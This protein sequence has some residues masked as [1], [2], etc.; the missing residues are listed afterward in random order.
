MMPFSPEWI[1]AIAAIL[2]SAPG[3]VQLVIELKSEGLDGQGDDDI[4]RIIKAIGALNKRIVFLE[5]NLLKKNPKST[6]PPPLPSC[7]SRQ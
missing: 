7:T 2:S 1:A 3:I 6:G 4:E 5:K